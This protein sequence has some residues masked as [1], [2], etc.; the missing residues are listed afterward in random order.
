MNVALKALRT[1]KMR[2]NTQ[3][4]IIS[5]ADKLISQGNELVEKKGDLDYEFYVK[6]KDLWHK[7]VK[8]FLQRVC[9]ET[10]IKEYEKCLHQPSIIGYLDLDTG[11]IK[12]PYSEQNTVEILSTEITTI[13]NLLIAVREDIELFGD[14]DTDKQIKKIKKHFELEASI[15]G[16][17]KAKWGAKE[18]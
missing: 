1:F 13:N 16:I 10:L 11:N 17:A 14:K 4:R 8:T 3:A 6:E 18:D 2:D 9:G 15:P 7:R 12:S 5:R